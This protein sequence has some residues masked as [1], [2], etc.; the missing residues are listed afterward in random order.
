MQA[1]TLKA[2]GGKKENWDA[3]QAA[4]LKRA[5]ANGRWK[6]WG[7]LDSWLEGHPLGFDL[8]GTGWGLTP[9]GLQ[10]SWWAG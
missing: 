10:F 2:W 9:R 1:S 5:K 4:F 7:G 6:G 3:A 8:G